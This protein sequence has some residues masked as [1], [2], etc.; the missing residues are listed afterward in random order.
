MI[1]SYTRYH[2]L[3]QAAQ[4]TG[5][6]ASGARSAA[7]AKAKG[8]AKSARNTTENTT[9]AAQKRARREVAAAWWTAGCGVGARGASLP[10]KEGRLREKRREER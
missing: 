1:H 6:A 2:T 5:H 10:S 8:T 4:D 9:N 3:W 7:D